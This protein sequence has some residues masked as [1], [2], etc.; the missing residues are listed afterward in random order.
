MVYGMNTIMPMEYIV[1]S[2]HITAFT[3]ME[4]PDIMEEHLAHL[5]ALEEDRFIAKFH[6]QV[7]KACDKAWHDRHIGKKSF[8][9][10]DLVLLYDRQFAKHPGKF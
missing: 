8:A 4:E 3:N 1:P 7:Q 5:V 9:E 10:G 6:K 2:L